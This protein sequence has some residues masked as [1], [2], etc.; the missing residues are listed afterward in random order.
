MEQKEESLFEKV[1]TTIKN[2]VTIKL[3]SIGTLIAILLIPNS[4]IKSLITERQMSQFEAIEEVSEKWGSPLEI[5]GPI[6]TIPFNRMNADK[7]GS[8]TTKHFAHFLPT[9]LNINGNLNPEIRK[10]GIYEVIVYNTQLKLEGNFDEI[11][12][13]DFHINESQIL[14]EEA[15][16]SIGIPDMS[17]IQSAIPLKFNN[18]T[19]KT[20]PGIPVSDLVSSGVNAKVN[21]TKPEKA[22]PFSV[23]LNINGTKSLSFLPLG[24]NTNVQINSNWPHPSFD[25]QFLPDDYEINKEGFTAKWSVFDLNRNYP[26]HWEGQNHKIK[27]SNFGVNLYQP[28]DNY[29]RNTRSAKYAVLILFLTFI[30]FFFVEILNKKRIH[31]VQYILV[32]LALTVF[33]T[34]LLSLSEQVGFNLAYLIA[35]AIIVGMISMYAKSILASSKLAFI[36]FAF[37]SL[38]Y[39]FIFVILQLEDFALLV[40]SFGLVLVLGICMYLS[41][42]V[43]WY[44]LKPKQTITH[45]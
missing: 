18:D 11:D 31:P 22:I 9:A 6:L 17:G 3:L 29:Q 5:A 24:K 28:V 19:Y 45:A 36:L 44:G 41:R 7:D 43:D 10:R 26:Q 38:I 27:T 30:T 40:G 14:W 4:M 16:V 12:F 39:S 13:D 21:L 42:K 15:F 33:Y 37:F 23:S 20:E 2:S 35:S 1:N 34:L 8:Y 32:G 25:G